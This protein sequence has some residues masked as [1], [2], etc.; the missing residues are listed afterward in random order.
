MRSLFDIEEERKSGPAKFSNKVE[1]FRN[2]VTPDLYDPSDFVVWGEVKLKLSHYHEAIQ[3][4]QKLT[5]SKSHSA[6][7]LDAAMERNPEVYDLLCSLLA[8]GNSIGFQD[9][10]ELPEKLPRS[11]RERIRIA[12]LL[13]DI[14]IWNVLVSGADI[15]S[16][17]RVALIA[18]TAGKRRFRVRGRFES[19]I[20]RLLNLILKSSNDSVLSRVGVLPK[21]KFPDP[22]R[23][24]VD[25]VLAIDGIPFA[26]I[27]TVFQEQSGGRQQ[28]DLSLTYPALQ[29]SLE[30]NS[31]GLILIADGRGIYKSPN[32]VL[33]DLLQE[34]SACMTLS[35]AEAGYLEQ[36]I[37]T[38]ALTGRRELK[39]LDVPLETIIRTTLLS[40]GE[41]SVSS[42]PATNKV[43]RRALAQYAADHPELALTLAPDGAFLSWTR[44]ELVQKSVN[45]SKNSGNK[46][47]TEAITVVGKLLDAKKKM[48][49]LGEDQ[50]GVFGAL[51]SDIRDVILPSR[52]LVIATTEDVNASMLRRI[53][54]L[55]TRHAPEAKLATLLAPTTESTESLRRL[56]SMLSA[57]IVI[58][59][60]N[61]LLN[62]TR[63]AIPLRDGFVSMILERTDLTKVSPFVVRGVTPERMFFGREAEH[64]T[65]I[66]TLANNSVALLGGRRIGKT[67]LMQRART[68]L[69]EANF[70]SFFADCQAVG[71]W[72]DFG[73]VARREWGVDVPQTF[74]PHFLFDIISQLGKGA[75][76]PP[77]FL[78]DEI[79]HLL[80]WDQ[81]HL[82][83]GVRESF[84]RS[85]RTASQDGKAQFVF[86]GERT[87]AQ[88]LWDPHS[89]HWNFCRPLSLQQL[90][91]QAAEQLLFNPLQSLQVT[92]D[93]QEAFRAAMWRYTGG[94][95]QL[96]QS[97]GDRLVK[98]LNERPKEARSLIRLKDL[99][100]VA[101][102]L[103]FAEHYLETY[104]GQAT[105]LDRLVSVLV[106]EGIGTPHDIT[107]R[108]KR[109]GITT[110][111][112][113]M[114]NSL[115]I[116]ELYG[117]IRRD[118]GGYIVNAEWFANALSYYGGVEQVKK[119]YLEKLL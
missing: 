67:S 74:K 27:A 93:E 56:Q 89:P 55:S 108:L 83:H 54:K 32:S 49:D 118:G 72:N 70:R 46:S 103:D 21:H 64:A 50:P 14:G 85:C 41:V 58:I 76:H 37:A 117:I 1:E 60:H 99:K 119:L 96:V 31:V 25:Y 57:A 78:L 36:A 10:R 7:K 114:V 44:F 61:D 33:E 42:L 95:P 100:N 80:S 82:E 88:R 112:T 91:R 45:I 59:D 16:M 2:S 102:C 52:M 71:D 97:L 90:S 69:D 47:A 77:I 40:V 98:S 115:R 4:A 24:R 11:S 34:L 6:E 92:I 109:Q 38:L 62:L 94:H 39:R 68:W 13:E 3:A 66:S 73:R 23:G 26:A 65:L 30:D 8:V 105:D 110:E 113:H 86:S 51:L 84:F 48:L 15:Q 5:N 87:I 17:F 106:A 20:S 116:L 107:R 12:G 18:Q 35:Q 63:S 111:D 43:A 104:W 19:R 9:G 29:K 53:A 22:A 101:E 28:R 75:E 79:D 81:N